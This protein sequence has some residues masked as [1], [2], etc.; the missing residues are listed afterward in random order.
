ML[1]MID[2]SKLA[3]PFSPEVIQWRVGSTNRDKTRGMALAYVDARA[4]QQRLDDVL[5]PE[6]WSCRYIRFDS[7]IAETT[8]C[9]ISV[10]CGKDLG[11]VGKCDGSGAT[12]FE[13]EKGALSSAFKRAAVPW[14]VG[15]YLYDLP[16]P[17]V[18]VEMK[19]KFLVISDSEKT[20]LQQLVASVATPPIGA[21]AAAGDDGEEEDSPVA[22]P[23]A[24]ADFADADVARCQA[25][26]PRLAAALRDATSPQLIDDILRVQAAD[27]DLLSRIYPGSHKKLLDY[28]AIRRSDFKGPP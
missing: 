4:V 25:A 21:A 24:G 16:A 14:G 11:W 20:R 8:L 22:D 2:F 6:N 12:D 19:G 10:W 26:Y 9:E 17:W 3:A 27:I 15:R 13:A 7:R 1:S 23:E 28:A 5:G 18:A